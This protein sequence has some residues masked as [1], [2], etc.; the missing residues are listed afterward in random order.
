MSGVARGTLILQQSGD[1]QS[2]Y[3]FRAGVYLGEDPDGTG[4]WAP[5]STIE[6]IEPGDFESHPETFA[7][8]VNAGQQA[9]AAVIGGQQSPVQQQVV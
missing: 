2:G 4:L 6:K 5:F 3:T 1:E 7:N 9:Q 8:A